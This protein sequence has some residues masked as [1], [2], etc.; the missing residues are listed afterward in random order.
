M[1]ELVIGRAPPCTSAATTRTTSSIFILRTS[2]PLRRFTSTTP[3]ARPFLPTAIRN[4]SPIRSA[5]LNF[6]PARSSRSS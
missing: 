1:R 2:V 6:T 5:S 3:S 4:G